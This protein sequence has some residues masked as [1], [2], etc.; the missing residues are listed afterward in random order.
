[1]NGL[2]KGGL[3]LGGVAVGLAA[4]KK[5]LNPSPRYAAWEKPPYEEF[6]HK[7]LVVGG[8]FGGYTA[9][10]EIC[11]LIEGREDVGVL[12][13][14]RDNFFLFWPMV[15][16]I[17]SSEVESRNVAQPLRRALITAGASFRR[18]ELKGIN[19]EKKVIEAGGGV[20]FPY[21][22]L[23]ISLGGEANF[24]GIPG[25]EEHGLTMRGI[26]DAEIVRNRVIERFEEVSLMKGEIPESK[27]TFVVIGGGATGVEVAS[28]IHTLVHDAL[29]PDYPNIDPHRVR[30][31][32]LEA[33]DHI[34]PELDPALRRSAR[35]RLYNQ[36]IEVKTGAMAEEITADCVKLKGEDDISSENVIWTAGNRP[37]VAIHELGLPVDEKNGIKV[38]KYLRVEDHHDIWAIGDCAAI[39]DIREENGQQVPPN[40]QAAQQEGKLVAR[41]I[42]AAIDG[43]ELKEFEYKPLGQLVELGSDF[44]VNEVMGVRFTGRTAA[45]FWRLAYLTRLSSPQSK[46][47]Q[48]ADWTLGLF[49]RPA[50]TQYRGGTGERTGE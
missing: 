44:A 41:N 25:V 43:K 28:E 14:S 37:N 36:R 45:I 12:V 17:V 22:Q 7:V 5:A 26:E 10:K 27:L 3:A 8:G 21:D 38:D 50:V 30:I 35:T 4:L 11:D 34:L 24:F 9:A 42:L 31:Y 29:A 13:M 46:A 1:M 39:P 2:V 15:A 16:S 49:M 32:L 48:M 19:H 47:R 20:E 23:V 18:A 6:E 40:A 33:M